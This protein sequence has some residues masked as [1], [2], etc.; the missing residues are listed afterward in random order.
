VRRP[1]PRE[2]LESRRQARAR[3]HLVDHPRST[4]T[5]GGGVTT[6]QVADVTLPRT[7]LDRIWSPEY[8]E[9]LART[10]WLFLTRVSL[11]LLRV[12]Y[13]PFSREVV[14]LRRPFR[15]LT[16]R[17]PRYRAEPSRGSVTWP[18]DRGIL[19]APNGRGKGYLR[20]TVE[21]PEED[22]SADHVTI[23]VSS[24]VA[25]FYPALAAGWLPRWIARIGGWL[26]RV[27]QLRIHVIVTNAFLR[28][29]ARLDLAPS[30]VGALRARADRA[31]AAGDIDAAADAT[32]AAAAE[33]RMQTSPT[34]PVRR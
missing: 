5:P 18:I 16:F 15:L 10:Y 14:V 9:R 7:E 1:H 28:S 24:E 32:A 19:V 33:E 30:V 8:L 27:T 13:S 26:Y 22:G 23:R 21:R 20:I 3:V 31:T 25:N 34:R 11:G 17:G 2:A 12:V 6:K 4:T 29:L